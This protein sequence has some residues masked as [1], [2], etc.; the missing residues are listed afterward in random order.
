MQFII[1]AYDGN[2]ANAKERR[3]TFRVAIVC[4]IPIKE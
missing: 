4:I 1:T 2:D 3:A